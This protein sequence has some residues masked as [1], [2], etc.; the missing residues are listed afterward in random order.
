MAHAGL[1]HTDMIVV[2][3]RG[4]GYCDTSTCQ[5]AAE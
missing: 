5:F 2:D 4:K 1:M 3:D